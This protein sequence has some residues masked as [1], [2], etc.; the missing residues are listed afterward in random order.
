M[1]AVFAWI[2][3]QLAFRPLLVGPLTC[4]SERVFPKDLYIGLKAFKVDQRILKNFL[5]REP[6]IS[7]SQSH[8]LLEV[9]FLYKCDIVYLRQH[10][11]HKSD[12]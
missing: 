8:L 6:H 2:A 9:F 1:Q 7:A 5:H 12:V 4:S 3:P 10:L 11:I